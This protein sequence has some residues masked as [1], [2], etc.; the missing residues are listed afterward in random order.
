MLP[1]SAS[2]YPA[3]EKP[4]KNLGQERKGESEGIRERKGESIPAEKQRGDGGTERRRRSGKAAAQRRSGAAERRARFTLGVMNEMVEVS[5]DLSDILEFIPR[6]NEADQVVWEDNHQICLGVGDILNHSRG[7]G[8]LKKLMN[9]LFFIARHRA[10]SDMLY[11]EVAQVDI[12]GQ[13]RVAGNSYFSN[14]TNGVSILLNSRGRV[15]AGELEVLEKMF[16]Y[17][18]EYGVDFGS[19]ITSYLKER[20]DS[21]SLEA[22]LELWVVGSKPLLPLVGPNNSGLFPTNADGQGGIDD[23][24]R[25]KVHPRMFAIGDFARFRKSSGCC[26]LGS[27]RISLYT[28]DLASMQQVAIQQADFSGWN[29]WAAINEHLCCH[30]A[31]LQI[32]SAD[33]FTNIFISS[34]FFISMDTHLQSRLQQDIFSPEFALSSVDNAQQTCSP[35]SFLWFSAHLWDVPSRPA[36]QFSIRH[37]LARAGLSKLVSPT[38]QPIQQLQLPFLEQVSSFQRLY[39]SLLS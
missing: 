20:R 9:I 3:G 10:P 28:C 22:D 16:K 38:A 25:V 17:H 18:K 6:S 26:V 15:L 7:S 29:L 39:C 32:G 37:S 19:F 35:S 13:L 1:V 4:Q 21:Q 34:K 5:I 2:L 33:V 30:S 31:S 27:R 24:L 11:F 14:G 23:T 36:T 8:K 12:G